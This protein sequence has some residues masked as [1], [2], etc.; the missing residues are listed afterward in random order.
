MHTYITHTNIH[1]FKQT[2]MHTCM[3]T[4]MHPFLGKALQDN[5][6]VDRTEAFMQLYATQTKGT[7]ANQSQAKNRE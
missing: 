1:A 3:H 7:V 5:E 4:C 2:Y 6:L